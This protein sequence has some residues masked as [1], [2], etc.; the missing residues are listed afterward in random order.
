MG[1]F[2]RI[3]P[4]VGGLVAH[5]VGTGRAVQ[6]VA[7]EFKREVAV[8]PVLVKGVDLRRRTQDDVALRGRRGRGGEN[9]RR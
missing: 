3:D 5:D 4:G 1:L 8:V 6:D 2:D 7:L 9:E